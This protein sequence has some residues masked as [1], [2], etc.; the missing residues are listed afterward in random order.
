VKRFEIR[1][2]GQQPLPAID[3]E[4][5]AIVVGSGPRAAVRLP[6]QSAN[7][8]HVR[9]EEDRWIAIADVV[10]DGVKRQAGD[11]GALGDNTF[12]ID[13]YEVRVQQTPDGAPASPPQRTESLARELVRG[14]LGAS[15][16][17]R[18]I[19]GE[20]QR[21]LAPPDSRLVIGRGDEAGWVILD[22][23]LSREHAEVRRSWDGVTIRDLG[24]KNGTRVD[25]EPIDEV[26]PLHDGARIELGNVVLEFRDPAERSIQRPAR[27]DPA[28][29]PRSPVPFVVAAAIAG[30]AAVGLAW[31]L[32]A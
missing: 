22:G 4:G 8:A 3:V 5:E 18:L 11:A 30:L 24:S 7:E 17:P 6:A 14:L 29:P 15:A 23:D 1:E 9:I 12:E 13:R 20:L 28:P 10:V 16:A 26:V 19:R 32:L 27:V 25:G 2:R 31:I 21:E